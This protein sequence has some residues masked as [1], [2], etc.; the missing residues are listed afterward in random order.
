MKISKCLSTLLTASLWLLLP[1]TGL[2]TCRALESHLLR[3][4]RPRPRPPNRVNR[5]MMMMMMAWGDRSTLTHFGQLI[6]RPTVLVG[7]KHT[8]WDPASGIGHRATG[9]DN[10]QPILVLV[11]GSRF[12]N[13]TPQKSPR[14]ATSVRRRFAASKRKQKLEETKALE[15]GVEAGVRR[16]G[17]P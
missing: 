7:R 11:Y 15:A 10:S 17:N 2:T 8:P 16:P 1:L 6:H 14:V 5:L 3:W 4:Q 12:E 9:I 13:C